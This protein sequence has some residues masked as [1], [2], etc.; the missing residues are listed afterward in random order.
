[1]RR[2]SIVYYCLFLINS[3]HG[4]KEK[5]CPLLGRGK[6]LPSGLGRAEIAKDN[7]LVALLL[8]YGTFM[9]AVG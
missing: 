4:N 1:M 5:D 2:T 9:P 8:L 6:R 7:I 3:S